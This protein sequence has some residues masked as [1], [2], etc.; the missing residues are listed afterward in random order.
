VPRRIFE[1]KEE[2]APFLSDIN[3]GDDAVF[4]WI[5]YSKRG[6]FARHFEKLNNLNKSMPGAHVNTLTQND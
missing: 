3:N 5:R 2:V 1:L 6:L 4:K